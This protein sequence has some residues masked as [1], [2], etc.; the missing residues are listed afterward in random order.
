MTCGRPP[1]RGRRPTLLDRARERVARGVAPV[2]DRRLDRPRTSPKL[3]RRS[4][5]SGLRFGVK[6][7]KSA[8]RKRRVL[9]SRTGGGARFAPVS[10]RTP[11]GGSTGGS[12]YSSFSSRARAAR[13]RA[14]RQRAPASSGPPATASA[15]ASAPARARGAPRPAAP[16]SRRARARL[17]RS[18]LAARTA[19]AAYAAAAG[20][21]RRARLRRDDED[22]QRLTSA[23]AAARVGA[24]ACA[25]VLSGS[26]RARSASLR[27]WRDRR[28]RR[29]ARPAPRRTRRP[30]VG[31][32][33]LQ[34]R[35]AGTA[36]CASDMEARE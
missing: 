33:R 31:N 25:A 16:C 29:R 32:R 24:L 2:R 7:G 13:V 23:A 15:G 11:A 17:A 30:S 10:T 36:A 8:K 9:G 35:L 27:A 26:R 28:P 21:R 6:F 22:F 18:P 4:T 3:P 12:L 5:S 19:A 34:A 1:R 14:D 20:G